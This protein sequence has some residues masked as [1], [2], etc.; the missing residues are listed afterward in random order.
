ME[1]SYL[2]YQEDIFARV[3]SSNTPRVYVFDNFNNLLI[4][5]RY[6]QRPFLQEES[7]FLTMDDLKEKLFPTDRLILKEEKRSIFFYNLLSDEEKEK[8]RIENYFDVIDLAADFFKLYDEFNE[9]GLSEIEEKIELQDWQLEKYR[10]LR[11]VRKRYLSKMEDSNYTDQTLVFNFEN[12]SPDYFTAYREFVFVN[13]IN[14]T[15]GEKRLLVELEAVGKCVYIY[16]QVNRDD[17][18][19]EDLR[20]NK[21]SL[22]DK[23]N[24]EV[25]LYHS[26]E[27]LLQLANL[28]S[29]RELAY[30]ENR[31]LTVLDAAYNDSNYHQLLSS[32]RV[33]LDRET[34]F[35]ETRLYKFLELFYSILST[36]DISQG[37]LKLE[38]KELL[39]A[40]YFPEFS[41]YYQIGKES[42][43]ALKGLA[44]EDYVYLTEGLID[45]SC[46]KALTIFKL[47]FAELRKILKVKKLRELCSILEEIDFSILDDEFFADN[48][49]QY[50][51]GLLELSSIEEIG[52]LDSWDNY[53]DSIPRGLFLLTINY[54]KFKKVILL[55]N[56]ENPFLEIKDLLSASHSK[57]EELIITN[58][59]H[60]IIPSRAGGGFF[61]T[62]KQRV[63]LGLLTNEDRVLGE[64]YYFF[65]HLFSSQRAVI[66]SLQ[67]QD[68]NLTISSFIEEIRLA[69]GLEISNSPITAGDYPTLIRSIFINED[70]ILP[71]KLPVR[72]RENDKLLIEEMDFPGNSYCL[73]YYK[74]QVLKDC[75]YK[76]YLSCIAQ[77][78]DEHLIFKK[79]LS[80]RLLGIIVHE[81]FDELITVN[82]LIN[83]PAGE[84]IRRV[85]KEKMA[86]YDLKINDYYKKYYDKILVGKIQDSITYFFKVME[87][88][89]NSDIR[90]I[91]TEWQFDGSQTSPFFC[92]NTFKLYLMGRIDLLI[93]FDDGKQIIDFKTGGSSLDQL[94]FYSLLINKQSGSGVQV[95]KGIYSLMDEKYLRGYPDSEL[96]LADEITNNAKKLIDSEEYKAS[97]KARCKDCAYLDICKVV[98]R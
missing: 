72:N 53:F 16:L 55:D 29:Y 76:F 74:Y 70:D 50:F 44:A 22:P 39:E 21:L 36:T 17:Y 96:E 94:D 83:K 13:I 6:Y 61:L 28:L 82:G 52:L 78:E 11:E 30:Y 23:I 73:S 15:P 31:L 19:E 1:F 90:N 40:C 86:L 38:I 27:D 81:I 12:F 80:P 24:T 71:G 62:E 33:K 42:L 65:R 66:Y 59:S 20:L 51:D 45:K 32:D 7:I 25:E 26:E 48:I 92:N 98:I 89:V 34:S 41:A 97:Y 79:E 54:L 18:N 88:R 43:T 75:F 60:G 91:K 69:Y 49:T 95:E 57:R 8:L 5:R 14:F 46:N 68:S 87:R 77:L 67:N 64:K 58:A 35:S 56:K 37:S 4:A 2:D 10:I 9:Y 47:I 85:I 3:V 84:E 93:E 63:E